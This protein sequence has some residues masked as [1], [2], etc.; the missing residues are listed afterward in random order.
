MKTSYIL[1]TVL[2]F[3]TLTG[4]VATDVLLKQQYERI[5]WRNPYQN[6]ENRPLPTANHWVVEGTPTAE[7]MI[8]ASADKPQALLAPDH[9]RYYRTK[10][11]G[12]TVFVKFTSDYSGYQLDPRQ[13]ASRGLGVQLVLRL[14]TL[15][16]LRIKDGRVTL[17][18]FKKDSLR[19]T[20]QNSRL[21]TVGGK[22]TAFS[23][24]AGQNSFAVLGADQY[25]SLQATVQ[26]SSGIWLNN[27]QVNN[28]TVHASPKADVQLKGRALKWLK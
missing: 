7:I 4:M 21:R 1:L 6:F 14:P 23:V 11:Q 17:S 13:D 27:T 19:V 5:D 22:L 12:D 8:V 18:E 28:F 15:Q 16:T 2:A 3:I 10:Q 9:A 24:V 25:E 20:L 26:D